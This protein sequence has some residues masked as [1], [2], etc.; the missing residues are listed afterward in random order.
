VRRER[1]RECEELM[2]GRRRSAREACVRLLLLPLRCAS[3]EKPGGGVV[4]RA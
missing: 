1:E 4:L 3:W 2:A